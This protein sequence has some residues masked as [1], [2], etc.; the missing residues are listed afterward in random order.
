MKKHLHRICCVSDSW[1]KRLKDEFKSPAIVIGLFLAAL[2]I[3]G[4][5]YVVGILVALFFIAILLFGFFALPYLL[6]ITCPIQPE[7]GDQSALAFSYI[8]NKLACCECLR[9]QEAIDA[10]N[11]IGID[12]E[13]AKQ[14]LDGLI[15]SGKLQRRADGRIC[16]PNC[17][18]I[19][20][21]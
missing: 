12:D 7:L 2:G 20:H 15:E 19:A 6:R 11:D 9:E 1:F 4:L 16:L 14:I 21:E 10:L 13:R 8:K 18:D 17:L 3:W 5:G